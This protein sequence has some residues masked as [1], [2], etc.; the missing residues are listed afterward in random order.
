MESEENAALANRRYA[1]FCCGRKTSRD[2]HADSAM[3]DDFWI[4]LKGF[5]YKGVF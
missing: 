5:Y 2:P 3:F 4:L 1:N